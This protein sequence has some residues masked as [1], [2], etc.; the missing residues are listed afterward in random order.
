[1]NYTDYPLAPNRSLIIPHSWDMG[2]LIF[3]GSVL[4]L[5]FLFGLWLLIKR[6]EP[7]MLLLLVGCA[8]GEMLEPICDLLGWAFH[9]EI[10]QMVGF[11]TMGRKIPLWLMLCYPWYFGLFCYFLISKDANRTLTPKFYWKLFGIAAFFCLAIE[12]FPV[13]AVLWQYFGNQPLMFFGMPLMWYIVNPTSVVATASF[14]ALAVRNREGWGRWLVV[15]IL[16]ISIVG[17]HTGVFAPVYVV[18]NAGGSTAQNLL[19]A[20]ISAFF[21][22]VLLTTFSRML[23]SGRAVVPVTKAEL[24]FSAETAELVGRR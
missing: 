9:P 8:A 24:R 20:A 14:T 19:S 23:F 1:M 15:V 12:I 16:P 3:T 11:V 22:A 6:K 18:T 5:T 10:G 17:F 4:A 7:L 13:H 21:A 2:F